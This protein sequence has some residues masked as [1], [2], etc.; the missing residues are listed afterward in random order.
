M[1]CFRHAS[2][3]RSQYAASGL[4]RVDPNAADGVLASS[5]NRSW[6]MSVRSYRSPLVSPFTP[7]RMPRIFLIGEPAAPAWPYIRS[8]STTP[9]SDSLMTAVGPPDCPMTA[10]PGISSAI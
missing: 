8:P 1:S 2:K 5:C 4:S 10:L 9:T 6:S 7:W 3:I